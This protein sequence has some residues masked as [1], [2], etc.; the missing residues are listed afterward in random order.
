MLHTHWQCRVPS[1]SESVKGKADPRDS[2]EPK[3]PLCLKS[4]PAAA[5]GTRGT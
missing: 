4:R 1:G 5:R 3:L 2:Q